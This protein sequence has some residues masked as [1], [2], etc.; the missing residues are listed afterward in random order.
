MSVDPDRDFLSLVMAIGSILAGAF[1][2][3]WYNRAV[4]GHSKDIGEFLGIDSDWVWFVVLV[5][6]FV[7]CRVFALLL[8]LYINRS[9]GAR[10]VV[11]NNDL[12]TMG[13]LKKSH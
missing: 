6:T 8:P 9:Q 11:E 5:T 12:K 7:S 13:K 1:A 10:E 2:G 3:V 4:N